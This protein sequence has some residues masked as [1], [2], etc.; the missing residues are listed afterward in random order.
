MDTGRISQLLDASLDPRQNKQAEISL[1]QEEQKPGFSVGLLQI[2]AT[3]SF[4]STTRLSAALCF[5]NLIKRHWTDEEGNHI[6]PYDEVNNIKSMLIGLMVAVPPSIQ[7]QLG[8]AIGVIADSDFWERWDTLVDDLISRLSPESPVINIGVLQVAHSIFK[9]WRPLFRSDKLFAE[10]N[11]VVEKFGTPY[12]ELI[13]FTDQQ[14]VAQTNANNKDLL[15]KHF[16]SLN[17]II[18]LL[19]DLTCQDLPPVIEDNLADIAAILRKYLSYDSPLLHNDDEAGLLEIVKS[20]I[21]EVLTLFVQKYDDVFGVH[22]GTFIESSWALLT[23]IGTETKDDILVSKALQFLT[24]VTRISHHAQAFN[25]ESLLGQVV[26][27]VI[28]PNM[29]LRESDMELFEDEPIEFIRRDLEGPDNDTRRR[30]ATDFLRSLIDQFDKLVTEVV[31]RYITHYLN[32]YSQDPTTEFKSKDTAVYLFSAIA[33]KGTVTALKGVSTVNDHVKILEFFQANVASDLLSADSAHPI[34]QVDAI[35][36]LYIFRSQIS[37]EQWGDAFPL[38][39]KHL[40]SD[41]YVVYTYAAIAVE[42]VLASTNDA[43]QPVISRTS[44]QPLAKDLLSHLYMLIEKNQDSKKSVAASKIQENEFIMRCLMRVLIVIKEGVIPM[45]DMVLSHSI[46]ITEIIAVNPSNP[47][48]YYYHFEAL[49]ALIRFATPSQPEK[50]ETA[51]YPPFSNI[52]QEDVSEFIPYT[53]QLFAALLEANPSQSLP[54]SYKSLVQPVLLANYWL[55]KGNVPA[56]VRLLSSIIAKGATEL[57]AANQV[58]PILG[59]FKQL[60]S[61]KSSEIH[62]FDLL[63]SILTHFPQHSLQ[64][65]YSPIVQM[66][67][68]RLQKNKTEAFTSRFVRLYH[69]VSARL[70]QGMGADFFIRIVDSIQTGLYT[71]LYL[72]IILPE[73]AKLARPLDRKIAVISLTKT[74]TDSTAFAEQYRKGWGF[75]C[76]ALLKLLENPPLP[77]TTDYDIIVEQDVDDMSFGVGFTALTTIRK[78]VQDPYPDITDVK[79]WVGQFLRSS[80]ARLGGKVSNYAQERLSPQAQQALAPYVR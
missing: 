56:L 41:N 15:T 43:N 17:L 19:Y 59:I 71:Q 26:E 55:V 48:F 77:A 14:I 9:R 40:A 68:T 76:E 22:V 3:E 66:L 45:T 29:T 37:S 24:S 5:K 38:L 28:L 51:L 30:A 7:L 80:N 6:L 60:I 72:S 53:F 49:G 1:K 64:Q 27:G 46:A 65:Y 73:T 31:L 33:A 16:I 35:K 8:D 52:I 13:R 47:R 23:T 70:E 50:L 42:R 61:V 10:V 62:G 34:L 20:N 75:T 58:E 21:F 54:E 18:K 2:V 11:H 39:A 78:P 36:F 4:N 44:V 57:V 74:L 63:D 12:I 69:S 67:L 79:V 32:A 25:N